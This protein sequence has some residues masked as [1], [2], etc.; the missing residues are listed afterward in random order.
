MPRLTR[1]LNGAFYIKF[2]T[3]EPENIKIKR[4]I[5]QKRLPKNGS[6]KKSID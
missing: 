1:P 3:T 4:R 2:L 5:K 6:L